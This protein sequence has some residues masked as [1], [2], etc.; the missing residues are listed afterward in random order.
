MGQHSKREFHEIL[1]AA[2]RARYPGIGDGV[3]RSA[4]PLRVHDLRGPVGNERDQ[5]DIV[6]AFC[7]CRRGVANTEFRQKQ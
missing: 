5:T 4:E 3:P 7:D 2:L 1:T 6:E